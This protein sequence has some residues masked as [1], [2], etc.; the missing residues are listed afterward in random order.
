MEKARTRGHCPRKF[1]RFVEISGLMKID[2]SYFGIRLMNCKNFFL[3]IKYF[4]IF[5]AYE[6]INIDTC[7]NL[8]K[9]ICGNYNY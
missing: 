7:E 5:V 3:T 1:L 4:G 6:S 9:S 2:Y 8:E